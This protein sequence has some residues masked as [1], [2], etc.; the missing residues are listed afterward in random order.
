MWRIVVTLVLVAS[1]L[2]VGL[3]PPSQTVYGCSDA[4]D[5]DSV[6]LS[7]V[8]VEG[9]LLGYEVL[10]QEVEILRD[11]YVPI[12]VDMAVTRVIKGTVS[13]TT[14]A[15]VDPGS[16]APPSGGSSE[17]RWIGS[18]GTCGAFDFDPTGKHA[19]MGLS[20]NDDGTYRLNR[21][22]TFFLGDS[23]DDPGYRRAL[24]RMASLPGAQGLP[25]LGSGPDGS[26]NDP[27][28]GIIV[29]GLILT[30]IAAAAGFRFAHG[31][32]AV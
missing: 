27:P 19:I 11:S 24:E 10:P 31:R 6:A 16:L 4:P 14:I 20:R 32:G 8:V 21:L 17:Y 1:G 2:L 9:R 22:D 12:R 25:V 30:L 5:R 23:P 28:L 3:A 15:M 13:T 29:G 26:G 18:S 7:D